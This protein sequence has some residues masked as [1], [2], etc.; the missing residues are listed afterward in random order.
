M[1]SLKH[2]SGEWGGERIRWRGSKSTNFQ[3]YTITSTGDIIYY[4]INIINTVV[5]YIWKLL[6]RVNPEFSPHG[7]GIFLFLKKNLYEMRNIPWLYCGNHFMISC[8]FSH[9]VLSD[10][11]ATPRTVACQTPLSMGFPRQEDWSGLSFPFPG[12]LPNP[13][14][15]HASPALAGRFSTREA[16]FMMDLSQITMPYTWNL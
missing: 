11:F 13:G 15:K 16:S 9:S 1:V 10:S 7:K 4:L 3:L 6:M 8:L 2:E 5:C 14:I 12:D